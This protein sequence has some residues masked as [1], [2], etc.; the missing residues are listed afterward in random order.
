MK[1]GKIVDAVL[2]CLKI[3]LPVLIMIPLIF[4]SYR[5][6][7][8]RLEDLAN[9]GNQHYHSGLGLYLFAS[10][11]VLLGANAVLAILGGAGWVIAAKCKDTPAHTGNVKVFRY[12]TFSPL[13]SEV[14]YVWV[15]VLVLWLTSG[16]A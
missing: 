2:L 4:F 16:A 11:A 9:V 6:I 15:T 8:G 14:A 13:F 10:H 7:E 1:K 5:L 3:L 12:L